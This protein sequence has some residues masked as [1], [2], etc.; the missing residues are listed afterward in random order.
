M[1]RYLDIRLRIA[2]KALE[3]VGDNIDIIMGSTL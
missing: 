2:E 1:D 3:E